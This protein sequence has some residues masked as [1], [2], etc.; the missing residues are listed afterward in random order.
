MSK[1]VVFESSFLDNLFT[2]KGRLNRLPFFLTYTG[3]FP[4]NYMVVMLV[5]GVLPEVLQKGVIGVFSLVNVV[6]I[7]LATVRRLH[8]LNY[9]AWR[10]IFLLIPVINIYFGYVLFFRKGTQGDNDYGPD[11]LLS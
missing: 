11:P 4:L 5:Q 6:V 7:V 10:Y 3:L 1:S 2:Y 8:D 9:S